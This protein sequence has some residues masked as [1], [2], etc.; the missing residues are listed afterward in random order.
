[1]GLASQFYKIR[2]I[3]D[4]YAQRYQNQE[5][6]AAEGGMYYPEDGHW[7]LGEQLVVFRGHS[8]TLVSFA[9]SLNKC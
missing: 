3:Y 2:S 8:S 5:R 9:K 4:R 6:N 1:M 7:K